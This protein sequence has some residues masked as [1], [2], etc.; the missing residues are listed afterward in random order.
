MGNT[1]TTE[2]TKTCS[3]CKKPKPLSEFFKATKEIFGVD[4]YCKPCRKK[5]NKRRVRKNY[6]YYQEYKA[7]YWQKVKDVVNAKARERYER[8]K[9]KKGES[10]T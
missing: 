2:I 3:S 8:N 5:I 4:C 7:A 9:K 1:G 6:K 10:R